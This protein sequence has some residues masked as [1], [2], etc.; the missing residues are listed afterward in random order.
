MSGGGRQDPEDGSHSIDVPR[1]GRSSHSARRFR[2][3][4]G[5]V[6][7]PP[8]GEI[9]G[10]GAMLWLPRNTFFGSYCRLTATSRS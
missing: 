2:P 10:Y 6:E 9:L 8:A 1:G 4:G 5:I 3:A 7:E